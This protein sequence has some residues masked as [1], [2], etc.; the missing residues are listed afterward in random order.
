M[1]QRALSSHELCGVCMSR[2]ESLDSKMEARA[3]TKG[4]FRSPKK[5]QLQMLMSKQVDPKA[6]DMLR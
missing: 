3:R 5:K 6:S 2:C 4:D 1:S